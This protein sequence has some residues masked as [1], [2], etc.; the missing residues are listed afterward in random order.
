MIRKIFNNRLWLL[1][2][3]VVLVAANWLASQFHARIDLTNE[4]R[5]TLSDGTKKLIRKIDEP[6][7]IDVFLKGN[8]P[9]G[10]R[11]LSAAAGDLLQ[12][13]KEVGGRKIQYNFISPDDVV[14]GTDVKY[15]D[16]L[17]AMG[18][19][20]INLTSQLKEGQ[21]QQF[22]YPFALL[23]YKEKT[24][25]VELFKTESKGTPFEILNNEETLMEYRIASGISKILQKEKVTVGYLTGNGEPADYRSYDLSQRLLKEEYQLYTFDVNSPAAIPSAFNVLMIVKPTTGFSDQA[26]LK[27]DQ[28]VMNGGKLLMFIDRLNAEMDS[29]AIKNEVTAFDRDLKL[30]DLLFNYG[31]RINA[32]L[33][34]DL[35]CDFLPVD[36]N[37]NGQYE[38]QRWNYFP[39]MESAD[40]NPI[41]T[42]IG[43]VAGK[44][45]NSIDTLESEGI[46]KTVILNSSANSRTIGSP[47]VIS[48]TQNVNAPDAA[49][50][51]KADIPTAVLLEGKFHSLYANRLSQEMNDSLAAHNAAFLP[52]NINN[53]KMIVVSDGDIVL[54]ALWKGQPTPMGVNPYT[55]GT[56]QEFPIANKKFVKNCID[57]LADEN[58]NNEAASKGA[59]L[60]M[61]DSSKTEDQKTFWQGINI[62][63]PVLIILLFALI[64]QWLRKRKYTK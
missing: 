64:F 27:I 56:Q 14:P 6:V 29:L 8:Y 17:V 7:T 25:P 51:K 46:K 32:D 61:L 60:R 26:K 52:Q 31:V 23:H 15:S 5:F 2:L 50:F 3:I 13:F 39:I 16:T 28:Y 57:Y 21:Q 47:A 42:G 4:K 59:V 35:Q 55:L 53:N 33:V 30:N 22:V 11:Q 40:K 58:S 43:L 18:L 34:M 54:N 10:F 19:S 63:A 12:E 49:N 24:V 62:L 37:G 41:S 38:M 48:P 9:S 20:P 44:F 1:I 45:V 36:V